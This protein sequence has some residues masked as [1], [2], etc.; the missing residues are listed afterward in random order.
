V[1]DLIVAADVLVVPS[2]R[3]GFGSVLLE[4][5]ALETPIVASDLSP[6]REVLGDDTAGLVTPENPVALAAEIGRIF[7]DPP[8]SR[9]R[10]DAARRRFD[11]RFTTSAIGDE[12]LA[13]YER[14]LGR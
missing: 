14:A 4:A 13:F 9:R 2:R 5:M 1:P 6:I 8:G 3:E 10:T 7:R 11:Q 12:M